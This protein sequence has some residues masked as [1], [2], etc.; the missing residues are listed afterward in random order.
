[1]P[2]IRQNS[3]LLYIFT[4]LALSS[5]T[6]GAAQ[7]VAD[8]LDSIERRLTRVENAIQLP[9]EPATQPTT[10]PTTQPE[11]KPVRA[12]TFEALRS[13]IRNGATWIQTAGIDMS[14]DLDARGALIELLPGGPN[15]KP[16]ITLNG[17]AMLVNATLKTPPSTFNAGGHRT[18]FNKALAAVGRNMTLRNVVFA[19]DTGFCIHLQQGKLT[20]ESVKATTFSEYFVYQEPGT[21]AS[22]KWC[23]V[24]GGSKA[25]SVWRVTGANYLIEECVFDNSAGGK[26]VLRGDSPGKDGEA[27]G[28]ARRTRFVG[29]VGPNPLTEDDGGQMVG[30]DRWRFAEGWLYQLDSARKPETL[31]LARQMYFSGATAYDVVR[32]TAD[33]FIDPVQFAKVAKGRSKLSDKDI[34]LTLEFR[35][36]EVGRHSRFLIED[37]EILGDLRLNAR[38]TGVVRHTRIASTGNN[39]PISGN[40][41]ST[42][43]LPIDRVIVGGEQKPAPDVTFD[44]VEIKGGSSLG[45][46]PKAWPTLKFINGTTYG[47]RPIVAVPSSRLYNSTT[48]DLTGVPRIRTDGGLTYPDIFGNEQS[49]WVGGYDGPGGN[50]ARPA[51]WKERW[52]EYDEKK[53]RAYARALRGPM[54]VLDIEHWEVDPNVHGEEV[55]RQWLTRMADICKTI[56]RERPDLIIGVYDILPGSEHWALANWGAWQRWKETGERNNELP[57][58][59]WAVK[60]KEYRAAFENWQKKNDF[61]ATILLPAVDALCPSIYPNYR[62]T[63]ETPTEDTPKAAT[64][65]LTTDRDVVRLKIEEAIRVGGG[66]PVYPFYWPIITEDGGEVATPERTANTIG[67]ALNAGA[68]GIILWSDQ[69]PRQLLEETADA[70]LQAV[71]KE[72]DRP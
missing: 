35:E 1:M 41:Q 13:A 11:V 53:L 12:D 5:L 45:I 32:A 50:G 22:A 34:K 61:T 70:I 54:F 18:G 31:A 63:V 36:K 56:K 71:G 39:T 3:I 33:K 16:A 27:G 43:P 4:A 44:G 38:M 24:K 6:A 60:E 64:G 48:I 29:Q 30:I 21:Y 2:A 14:S 10:Q 51:S 19:P 59:W 7:Q 67:A 72:A 49:A 57:D 28:V 42:Y 40:S 68:A 9:T 55:A 52:R 8:R 15:W 46:D 65:V 66:K 26:A 37:C 62:M 17:D 47:D 25:E 20:L 58:A 23:E 69:R